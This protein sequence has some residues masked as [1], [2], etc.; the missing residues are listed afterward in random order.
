LA[1]LSTKEDTNNRFDRIESMLSGALGTTIYSQATGAITL[2]A[3]RKD[4]TQE[5]EHRDE[6]DFTD[7]QQIMEM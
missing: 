1:T 5:Q 6:D 3:K 7:S 4:Q 2:P